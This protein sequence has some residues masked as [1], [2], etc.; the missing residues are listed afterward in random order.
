[1]RSI[2]MNIAGSAPASAGRQPRGHEDDRVAGRARSPGW[3]GPASPG[4]RAERVSGTI[5][6]PTSLDTK[7]TRPRQP[8]DFRSQF[9]DFVR[10]IAPGEHQVAQPQG[11]AID[12]H[13][14]ARRAPHSRSAAT[15]SSGSSRVV[16]ARAAIGAMA[17]DARRHFVVA[18]LRGREKEPIRP[19]ALG[20]RLR[21]AALARASAAEHEHGTRRGAV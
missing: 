4:I 16:P 8:A 14:R 15:S 20:E 1:M 11:H 17:G 21:V 10:G 6:S 3:P 5:P 18:G 19:R 7:T 2:Q 9:S 13:E 12:E